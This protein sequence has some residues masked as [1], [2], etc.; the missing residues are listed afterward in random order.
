MRG[1]GSN[2]GRPLSWRVPTWRR[3]LPNRPFT[4]KLSRSPAKSRTS[5]PAETCRWHI[6]AYSGSGRKQ[7]RHSRC[8]A[9]LSNPIIINAATYAVNARGT[10]SCD[11]HHGSRPP[12][13][14][15]VQQCRLAQKCLGPLCGSSGAISIESTRC[16]RRFVSCGPL[17]GK[18]GG[19]PTMPPLGQRAGSQCPSAIPSAARAASSEV[20]TAG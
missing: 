8:L 1:R 5:A 13:G 9:W 4:T 15:E 16:G 10:A 11:P 6:F 19:I 17:T 20:C 12:A 14:S 18:S 2:L 3:C 7:R